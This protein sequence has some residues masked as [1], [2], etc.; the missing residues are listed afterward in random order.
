MHM[1]YGGSRRRTQ[2]PW[3]AT[4]CITELSNLIKVLSYSIG[5]LS[6]SIKELSN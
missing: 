3:L 1:V 2:I 4:M 6:N 5:E